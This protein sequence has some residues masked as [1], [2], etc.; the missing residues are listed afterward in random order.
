MLSFHLFLCL[1]CLLSPFTMPCNIVL[2]RPDE[3]E[4][5]PHH[6][7]L[8]LF[9]MVRRFSCGPVACWILTRTLSLV[10]WSLYEVRSIIS[11][12]TILLCSSVVRV[13]DSQAHKK[14]CVGK[15]RIGRIL[16]LRGF[17]PVVPNWSQP[18]Q[19]CCR[20]CCPWEHFRLGT[21]VNYNWAQ[22]LEAGDCRH[23]SLL[24]LTSSFWIA[25][26]LL[27]FSFLFRKKTIVA[28][29]T[30][31]LMKGKREDDNKFDD[32]MNFRWDDGLVYAPD[33][34]VLWDEGWRCFPYYMCLLALLHEAKRWTVRRCRRWSDGALRWSCVMP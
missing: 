16:E 6:F 13:H 17:S 22:V 18:W 33:K 32:Q 28:V 19:R 25:N 23:W 3:R 8:L 21:L 7:S 34:M 31:H 5:C 4:T 1:P 15:E 30:K 2:V 11:M 10:A 9:T 14:M 26:Y 24:T 20:Q 27:I 12:A 29:W